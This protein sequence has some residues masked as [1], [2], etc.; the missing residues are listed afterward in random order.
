MQAIMTL[1]MLKVLTGQQGFIANPSFIDVEKNEVLLAHDTI[2][3][4]M[5]E[6]LILRSHFDTEKGIA[7]Q[8]ILHEGEVTVFKCGS[9][10]LDEYYVSPGYL[11][12][13][14]NI[15]SLC[16]TQLL[17]KLGKP[18]EYFLRNPLGNHHILIQGNY[19]DIIQEFMQ[20]NRCKLRD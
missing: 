7:V 2:G 3:T 20:Q 1:L 9:E 4:K 8:G 6:R 14:T 13:N 10:C 18:V 15:I 19:C 16:R 11:T 17:V 12:E 5:A